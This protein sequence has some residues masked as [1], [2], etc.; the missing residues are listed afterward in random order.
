MAEVAY[1]RVDNAPTWGLYE[2]SGAT[3]SG[4]PDTF[5]ALKLDRTPYSLT[6]QAV[7]A[8]A[9]GAFTGNTPAIALHGS[10]DGTNY[11]ALSDTQG[12]AISLTANGLSSVG[13]PALHVKPVLTGGDAG[14]DI[15]VRLLARHDN[16]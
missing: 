4:S 3:N 5:T 14:T 2:W 1:T 13:I 11:F 9:G 6:V 15:A 8:D 7:D 10:L 12:T 16:V